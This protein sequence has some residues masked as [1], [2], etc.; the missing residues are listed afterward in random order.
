[1]GNAALLHRY[2]F[3]EADNPYDIV[4]IDLELVE[5]WSSSL[6]SCRHYRRRFSLWRRLDYSGCLNQNSGYFEI[7]FNGE[8]EVELL[9]VLYIMLLSEEVYNELDLVLSSRGDF[10]SSTNPFLVEK[11]NIAFCKSSS[12]NKDL[13]LTKRVR[14]AL[15]SLADIRESLYGSSSLEDDVKDLNKCCKIKEPSVYHSL[16]LRISER[17]ILKKFRSYA[18]SGGDIPR[19]PEKS[20]IRRKVKRT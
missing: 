5:K 7:S 13:L 8:P 4:N 18:A 10:Y 11:S 19:T 3:T 2:G 15:L 1:M 9:V 16:V 12:L 14:V 20:M 17:N 6:F